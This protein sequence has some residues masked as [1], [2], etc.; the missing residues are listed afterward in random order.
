MELGAATT[1]V[2]ASQLGLP[3]S[4]TQSIFGAT[5]AVGICNGDVNTINWRM[6]VWV[7]FGWMLTVPCAA[8]IAGCLFG[9]V[10]NTPR[11]G[12]SG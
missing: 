2:L 9:L 5:V 10:I 6:L 4:T 8:T 11:F 3:V 12:Y 7:I 1:V